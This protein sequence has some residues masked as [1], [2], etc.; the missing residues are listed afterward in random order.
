LARP[1]ISLRAER[2]AK[3][4]LQSTQMGRTEKEVNRASN[5]SGEYRIDSYISELSGPALNR[6]RA[7][8]N[9][10]YEERTRN[11]WKAEAREA[12]LVA[13]HASELSQNE[14]A[15][16]LALKDYKPLQEWLRGTREVPAWVPFALHRVSVEAHDAF[17]MTLMHRASAT[18]T[19]G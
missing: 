17:L 16:R 15:R 18:G 4:V 2:L 8:P 10:S 1:W 12:L 6:P 19:G 9:V 14:F 7:I 3:A 5:K 11:A 13:F